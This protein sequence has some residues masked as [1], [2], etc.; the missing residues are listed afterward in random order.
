MPKPEVPEFMKR[1]MGQA[2]QRPMLPLIGAIAPE[3]QPNP[4]PT[5]FAIANAKL[6]DGNGVVVLQVATPSGIAFYFLAGDY[7]KE[8]GEGLV[9]AGRVASAGLVALQG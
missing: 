6:P 8:I 5:A 2:A 3:A 7:A 1:A 4:T 9:D